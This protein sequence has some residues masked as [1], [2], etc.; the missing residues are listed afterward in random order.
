[1]Q[2]YETLCPE[3]IIKIKGKSRGCLSFRIIYPL[4]YVSYLTYILCLKTITNLLINQKFLIT[5]KTGLDF[6]R[7][8]VVMAY[9]HV[10]F[11]YIAADSATIAMT[12]V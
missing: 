5:I 3:A 6:V 10:S 2:K 7:P 4:V 8:L 12:F 9:K 1:M 11:C